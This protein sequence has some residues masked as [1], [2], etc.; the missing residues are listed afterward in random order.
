[1]VDDP[2]GAISVHAVCGS[3]GTLA[4]ALFHME[5]FK[6]E[7]L[8]SQLIGMGAAFLWAFS[9]GW[10]LSKLIAATVGMR[11]SEEDEIDGLDISEHGGDAYPVE[12]IPEE[13]SETP[14]YAAE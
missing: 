1:K 13:S 11:V 10:I 6:P 8:I 2:V 7:Q 9:M 12:E 4:V 14:V 3:W 5:G